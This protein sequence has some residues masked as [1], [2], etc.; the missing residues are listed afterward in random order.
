MRS[1]R[2]HRWRRILRDFTA[3]RA[4]AWVHV[5]CDLP[6]DMTGKAVYS[7][8]TQKGKRLNS[9]AYPLSEEKIAT[10]GFHAGEEI[11]I[12]S[13]RRGRSSISRKEHPA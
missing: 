7:S 1:K 8:Y 11:V 12:N 4:G 10:I 6:V 9:Y 5:G 3:I 2:L 13:I